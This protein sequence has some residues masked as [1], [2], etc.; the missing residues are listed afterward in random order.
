[1][2][3]RPHNS[4]QALMCRYADGDSRAFERL[5]R[6]L[7][8]RVRR[9]IQGRMYDPD[10]VDDLVQETFLRVHVSRERYAAQRSMKSRSV[11]AWFMTTA[12]RTMLDHM[13]GEYR[14]RA[15]ID[16]LSQGEEAAGFGAPAPGQTPEQR[17]CSVQQHARLCRRVC[18]AVDALPGGSREV[19]VRHKLEGH[20]MQ[21]IAKDLGLAVGTVRVRAHRAYRRLS[22]RL[23]AASATDRYSSAQSRMHIV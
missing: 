1:M 19:V 12:R 11:E 22:E 7:E 5:A 18:E 3:R 15:R 2:T 9:F 20:S 10:L 6:T 13:R 17:F 8:P 16:K 23:G 21:H 4:M 14:R